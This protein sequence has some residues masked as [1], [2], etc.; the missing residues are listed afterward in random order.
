MPLAR[1]TVKKYGLVMAITMLL[2]FAQSSSYAQGMLTAKHDSSARGKQ[3][4]NPDSLLK[5][6]DSSFEIT[7]SQFKGNVTAQ[8]KN[9]TKSFKEKARSLKQLP[10]DSSAFRLRGLSKEKMFNKP[11]LH[12][13]GGSINY[14]FNYRSNIDTPFS[15][16][17][18]V[19]HNVNGNFNF[20]VANLLPVRVNYWIRESNSSLFQDIRDV[21]IVFD[22]PGLRNNLNNQLKQKMQA[23]GDI[24]VDSL[25]YKLYNAGQRQLSD[26]SNWLGSPATTQLLREYREVLQIPQFGYNQNVSDSVN[27]HQLDSLHGRAKKFIALYDS[28]RT[29]YERLSKQVDSLS[30]E[31]RNM[32]DRIARYSKLLDGKFH[33]WTSFQRWKNELMQYQPGVQAVDKYKWLTGIRSFSLGRTP[34]NHSEL[35]AKNISITGI[36]FEYNSWYYVALTAG[37]VDYRFRDFVVNRFNR[38]PQY[39]YM[40]R[41][42]IGRL[43]SNYFIV[44]AFRGRKQ[45]YASANNSSGSSSINITGYSVETKWQVNPTTH[46]IAEAAG[47]MSPDYR[48]NPP[49]EQEKF[50]LS[51]KINKALSIKFY[52]VLPRLGAKL[53]G[54]YKY[55]GANFQ[56]FSSFQTNAAIQSWYLKWEQAFLKRKLRIT[57]SLR[58]NEFSNPYIQQNYK[59]NTIFKSITAVFRTRKWPV[60]TIGFIPMSQLTI[61]GGQLLE[62]RFQTLTA[63]LNHFYK[64]G[65]RQATTTVVYNQFY[66][67]S[68][69]SGFIYFNSIN[70]Y[71][72]QQFVFHRFTAGFAASHSKSTQY[73]LNV[74]DGNVQASFSERYAVGFG[75]KVNSLNKVETK[76][77]VSVNANIRITRKDM[78]YMNWERGYLPGWQNKLVANTMATVQYSRNF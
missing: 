7:S 66:N 16:K 6:I 35:T 47:S 59:S 62:S 17:N 25:L 77:G 23:L 9:Q 64:L 40:A 48:L 12:L 34:V 67:S 2:L 68:S 54:M 45:L 42:G 13:N 36:N 31:V 37:V 30:S 4:I 78:I 20:T 5:R 22:A 74:I 39:L 73:E 63:S 8:I 41:L 46:V 10:V 57:G 15:E 72:A 27:K 18:I 32:K 56:S 55:T 75:V 43:E 70:F 76:A 19:Q 24:Q 60:M 58:S 1:P 14:A 3:Y 26:V 49:V 38:S 29:R 50:S 44:S 51:D 33:D 52:S 11:A 65:T 21:Q 71:L 28:I 69:D 61:V 53:E